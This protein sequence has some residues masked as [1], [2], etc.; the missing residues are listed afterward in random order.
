M[1]KVREKLNAK[2][3]KSGGFTLVEMLIVVAIIA[4]L[5][6]ISIP[7]ISANLDEAKKG[8]DQAN[9]RSAQSMAVAY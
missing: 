3:R 9:E 2:L 4:I 7:L 1:K 5:I 6:A 8:V